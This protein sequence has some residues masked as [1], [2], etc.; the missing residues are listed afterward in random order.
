VALAT[1]IPAVVIGQRT[2]PAPPTI[3]VRPPAGPPAIG[4]VPRAATPAPQSGYSRGVYRGNPYGGQIGIVPRTVPLRPNGHRPIVYNVR[5]GYRFDGLRYVPR[6]GFGAC[7]RGVC[8]CFGARYCGTT[9]FFGFPYVVSP[10][11][12]PVPLPMDVTDQSSY[13]AQP[14]PSEPLAPAPAPR[15]TDT[16]FAHSKLII[17]GGESGRGGDALTIEQLG[18]SVLRLTW[19]GSIRPIR[20]ARVFVADST[21]RTLRSQRVDVKT[22]S[23]LFET[24][25]LRRRIAYAGVAVTFTD[26][27]MSTTMVPVRLGAERSP[28]ER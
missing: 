2:R 20:E 4:I 13:Y 22:P 3:V 27:V 19:L 7:V 6:S 15:S 11:V 28:P 23:A 9:L 10:Y 16:S 14:A 1:L 12:V 26:G 21:Q 24:R 5:P 8:G 17:V 25:E 18:D